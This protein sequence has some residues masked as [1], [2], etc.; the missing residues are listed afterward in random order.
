MVGTVSQSDVA[1][2]GE[3]VWRA[4]GGRHGSAMPMVLMY[5]S[6]APYEEDPYGITVSPAR[7]ERQ[8]RWL[9]RRGLRGVSMSALLTAWRAGRSRGLIG[10]TFDDGYADFVEY[11][12][13]VLSRY[14]LG[15]T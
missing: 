7:F 14:G 5:H 1:S 4:G 10:L 6:V 15:A 2:T 13:P 8:M 11:A 3:Q 12:L 9:R